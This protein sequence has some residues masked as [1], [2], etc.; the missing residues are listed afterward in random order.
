MTG[1]GGFVGNHVVS[2]LRAL[3]HA[4]HGVGRGGTVDEFVD[5]PDTAA[6]QRILG[7]FAPDSILH[8]AAIAEVGAAEAD[9]V[10]ALRVNA[11]GTSSV[12]EALIGTGE[13]CRFVLVS[14]SLVYGRVPAESQPVRE[15][16]APRPVNTYGWTKLAAE[17]HVQSLAAAL[18]VP[19]VILRPFNHIGRGQSSSYALSSFARQIVAMETAGAPSVLRVGDLRVRRDFLDVEDVVNAYL[20]V[21]ESPELEGVYNV[22]SGQG[23]LLADL[24]QQL[25]SMAKIDVRVEVAPERLR[26]SDC[27]VIVGDS[28]RLR[29]ATGW[30]PEVP[31]ERTLMSLLSDWRL[32]LDA[33][34]EV[35]S[36]RPS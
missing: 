10:E 18:S 1:A 23:Y 22:C 3:G 36:C 33:G 35:D 32:R 26:A 13:A 8:L 24:V 14:S 31:M 25:C 30:C 15:T 2:R 11:G 5:L 29:M 28:E 6:F 17:A 27:K 7:R 12:L 34:E 9:P 16:V 21:L 20:R 19:P 4:V